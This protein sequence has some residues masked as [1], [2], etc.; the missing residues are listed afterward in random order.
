MTAEDEFV[1]AVVAEARRRGYA[2]EQSRNGPQIDFGHK[3]LHEAH[4]R[5]LYPGILTHEAD[6]ASL[7]ETVAPGRPCTHEPM[8]AILAEITER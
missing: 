7:I 8:K 2:I 4:L 5:A 6:V 1:E 3:K